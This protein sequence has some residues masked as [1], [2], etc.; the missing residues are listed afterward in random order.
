MSDATV[1]RFR[2]Q[3]FAYLDDSGPEASDVSD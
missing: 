3:M 2:V 1:T